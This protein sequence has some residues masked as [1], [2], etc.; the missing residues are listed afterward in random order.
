MVNQPGWGDESPAR[1][2][3]RTTIGQG[4]GAI[5][6]RRPRSA[7]RRASGREVQEERER[8]FLSRR[9]LDERP[10]REH[11]GASSGNRSRLRTD[12]HGH[13]RRTIAPRLLAHMR[14]ASAPWASSSHQASETYR[15]LPSSKWTVQMP[16][17]KGEE[18]NGSFG[19]T[20]SPRN[21]VLRAEVVTNETR[22]AAHQEGERPNERIVREQN[23]P[24]ASPRVSLRHTALFRPRESKRVRYWGVFDFRTRPETKGAARTFLG[25]TAASSA[26][27]VR[28][29]KAPCRRVQSLRTEKNTRLEA[30]SRVVIF[31]HEEGA[32]TWQRRT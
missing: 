12:T 24:C 23:A 13:D 28:R 20:R 5:G 11:E 16:S 15:D 25:M 4:R 8:L 21:R 31:R 19:H 17:T 9:R 30:R 18:R 7:K 14:A 6:P 1:S 27:L 10:A 29:S 26:S 3:R 32:E 2:R 22:P